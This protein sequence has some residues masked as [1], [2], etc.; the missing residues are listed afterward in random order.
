MRGFGPVYTT[1]LSLSQ[2]TEKVVNQHK[3]E[4]EGRGKLDGKLDPFDNIGSRRT[5][6]SFLHNPF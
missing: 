2:L 1:C 3:G 4:A 5:A 6:H